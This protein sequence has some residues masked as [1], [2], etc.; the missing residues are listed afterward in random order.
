MVERQ[1]T[2]QIKC[3]QSDWGGEYRK[4]QPLLHK[5]GIQFRHPC[6]H[7]QQQ[8]GKSERKHHTIVETGLILL[9]EASMDLKFWWEAFVSTTYLVN[10]LPTPVIDQLSPFESPYHQKPDY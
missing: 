8:Q 1:F 9:V 4:L 6:P 10:R 7:K 2:T 5:L 3:L